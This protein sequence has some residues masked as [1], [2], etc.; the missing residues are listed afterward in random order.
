MK[1]ILAKLTGSEVAVQPEALV[2]RESLLAESALLTEVN[3]SDEQAQAAE[4]A[5][6]IRKLEKDV[7]KT[8]KEVKAPVIEFEDQIDGT[9]KKFITPCVAERER[10][11]RLIA[12]FHDHEAER[13]QAEKERRE[14]EVRRLEQERIELERKT[15]ESAAA[16]ETEA[17][18]D[19]AIKAEEEAKAARERA[20]SAIVAPVP[21][22][23]KPSGMTFRQEIRWELVDIRE[24]VKNVVATG[25]WALL[26]AEP[27]AGI[28]RTLL[29]S[30]T[31]VIPGLRVWSEHVAIARSK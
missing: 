9:A 12:R 19:A 31:Q 29:V 18:L 11:S 22:I 10:L 16:I 6:R 1:L 25:N 30:D 5:Q 14:R 17:D 27:N 3:N 4:L 28:L 15:K 23:E 26:R 21:R 13:I 20:D 24:F 8:R 2:Y 7:E